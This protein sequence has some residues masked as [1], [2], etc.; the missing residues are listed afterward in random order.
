MVKNSNPKKI[1]REY[2]YY[3]R[4]LNLTNNILDIE[5][6]EHGFALKQFEKKDF[7]KVRKSRDATQKKINELVKKYPKEIM[8]GDLDEYIKKKL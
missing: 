7:D 3:Y 1:Y 2:K 4:W 8:M 6:I 5:G